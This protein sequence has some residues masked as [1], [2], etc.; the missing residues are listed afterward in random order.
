MKLKKLQVFQSLKTSHFTAHNHWARPMELASLSPVSSPAL[1]SSSIFTSTTSSSAT[2][3]ELTPLKFYRK[4]DHPELPHNI[5]P[6]ELLSGSDCSLS[7]KMSPCHSGSQDIHFF[8]V[9]EIPYLPDITESLLYQPDGL[10][11]PRSP[12]RAT[13]LHDKSFK[14]HVPYPHRPSPLELQFANRMTG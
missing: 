9:E 6:T 8:P 4:V 10:W 2:C 12:S 13:Y 5:M 1:S 7:P 3:V 14:R 11:S